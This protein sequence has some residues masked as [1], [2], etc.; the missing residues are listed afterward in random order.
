MMVDMSRPRSVEGDQ[1]PSIHGPT[2]DVLWDEGPLV[3]KEHL[4]LLSGVRNVFSFTD[5]LEPIPVRV[6]SVFEPFIDEEICRVAI[7]RL[8]DELRHREGGRVYRRVT[9]LSHPS[10]ALGQSVGSEKG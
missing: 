3:P 4:T 5:S 1:T 9:F 6:V 7:E 8:A 10:F 2:E